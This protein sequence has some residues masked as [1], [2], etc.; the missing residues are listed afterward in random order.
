MPKNI[1]SLVTG[2]VVSY[3]TKDLLQRAYE[4]VRKHH[5]DLK[6]IVIDG[7]SPDDPCCDYAKGLADHRTKIVSV[8]YNIGHGRGMCLGIYYTDT[9]FA[10]LFDSDTVMLKSPV[11]DMLEMVEDDTFGVGYLEKVGLDGYDYGA[12]SN[13]VRDGWMWY[14]HP[15]FQLLQIKNYRKYHPYVH[16]GAPCYLTMLDIF[17]KGL[18]SRVLKEFPGLGHSSGRGFSWVGQPR[19]YIQ[20]D[21]AGTRTLRKASGMFEIEGMWEIRNRSIE[22]PLNTP[23][24]IRNETNRF[25]VPPENVILTEILGNLL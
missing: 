18:S 14:L 16:H 20:H 8:G 22:M 2:V 12:K 4:S 11:V 7:S 3:N 6:I 9:P 23:G 21:V 10:L 15:Y 24:A 17:R 25:K 13:H 19:E 5:P 1:S